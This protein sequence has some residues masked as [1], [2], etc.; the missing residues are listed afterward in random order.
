MVNSIPPFLLTLV[1]FSHADRYVY[2]QV[3]FTNKQFLGS[4]FRIL[5]DNC[6]STNE[7]CIPINQ[8]LPMRKS[9]VI[10]CWTR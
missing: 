2:L 5:Q 3:R 4:A 1:M 9:F 10:R 7:L 8:P 6:W